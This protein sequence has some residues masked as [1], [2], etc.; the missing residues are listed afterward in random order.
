MGQRQVEINWRFKHIYSI[1]GN[2]PNRF[3][4]IDNPDP[5]SGE[6]NLEERHYASRNAL[7]RTLVLHPRDVV[8]PFTQETMRRAQDLTQAERKELKEKEQEV[9]RLQQE[10]EKKAPK[11]KR[12][13][14]AKAKTKAKAKAE[15]EEAVD[16]ATNGAAPQGRQSVVILE[17]DLKKALDSRKQA[18]EKLDTKLNEVK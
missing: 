1:V 6:P 2:N 10:L 13:A 9:L 8:P 15:P 3:V 5:S 4:F 11:K 7:M 12:K 14:K 16:D 17:E 18:E